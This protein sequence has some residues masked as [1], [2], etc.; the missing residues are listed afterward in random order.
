MAFINAGHVVGIM[1]AHLGHLTLSDT[2][3][4]YVAGINAT[5]EA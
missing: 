4:S 2:L 5:I 1:G 3:P